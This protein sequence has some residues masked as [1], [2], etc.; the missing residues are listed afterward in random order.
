MGAAA[1]VTDGNTSMSLDKAKELAGELWSSELEAKFNAKWEEKEHITLNDLKMLVPLLFVQ[2]TDM[3]SVDAVK[4]ATAA[5]GT[6]WNEQLQS[7]FDAHKSTSAPSAHPVAAGATEGVVEGVSEGAAPEA[8][9]AEEVIEFAQWKSLVP[10]VFE[11]PAERDVRLTAEWHALLARKSE[12]NI[13]VNYE[14][15]NE[16]FPISK[17]SITAARIDED[18]GK[19]YTIINF[20]K[21]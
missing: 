21:R 11:T 14:M 5:A 19:S 18:Y 20:K 6:E 9:A 7:I 15:Y 16:E 3:L 1:S 8:T 10:M 17:N 13:V 2:L 4:V 12:G